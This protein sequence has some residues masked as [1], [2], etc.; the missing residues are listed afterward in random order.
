MVVSSSMEQ[1]GEKNGK[2]VIFGLVVIVFIWCVVFWQGL[3]TAIDIW[4]ISDIFNHCLFVLPAVGFFIYLKCPQLA[5]YEIVPNYWLLLPCIGS[6]LLYA[7]GLSGGVQLFMHV[8]MF[9]FLPLSIW[10]FLGN[11]LAAK[12]TFPLFFILFCIPIGEELIPTLQQI[13]ADMSVVMLNWSGVPIFRTGLYIEIPEGRFL[14]AEA[15]SGISFFI[16]SIVIGSLYA[17]LNIQSAARKTLF[18]TIAILFPVLA[19]A[20]RVFGIILTGHLSNM[21]YAVGADHLI[22]GWLFF[23]FVIICLIAI[24]ELIREKTADL[25][26]ETVVTGS[27]RRLQPKVLFTPVGILLILTLSFA[28]WYQIILTQLAPVTAPHKINRVAVFEQTAAGE[29]SANWSPEFNHAYDAQ[30]GTFTHKNKLIDMYVAWYPKGEGELISSL[31]R[32]Y[33]EESWTLDSR[34]NFTGLEGLTFA[35]EKIVNSRNIRLLTYWYVVDGKFFTDKKIAKLYEIYRI[36]FGKYI[37]SGIIILSGQSDDIAIE[38][39][40]ADFKH[41]LMDNFERLNASFPL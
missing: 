11:K 25:K 27:G 9:T 28:V 29:R 30:Q 21:E 40:T 20:I 31:N 8:A 2:A 26:I 24:G 1:S 5:P 6:L 16:A 41:M 38:Q 36:M 15:C 22:Y 39:D 13:T 33:L 32:L 14:V 12:I 4:L 3:I 35:I 37:G 18:M 7:I 23:S 17:Y 10:F 34:D 19:N